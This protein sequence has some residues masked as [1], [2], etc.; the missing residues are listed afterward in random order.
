M[1]LE[2]KIISKLTDK[3]FTLQLIDTA[4]V[5]DLKSKVR[6]LCEIKS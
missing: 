3:I 2:V 5:F 6:K 4:T 1:D